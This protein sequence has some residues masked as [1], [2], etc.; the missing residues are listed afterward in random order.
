G[1]RRFEM[2]DAREL[3]GVGRAVVPLVRAGDAVVDEPVPHRLPR[4]AAVVG[5]L[6]QLPEPARALRRVQPIRVGRRSREMVD[7]PASKVGTT[8]VPPFALSVRLEDESALPRANQYPQSA[9]RSLLVSRAPPPAPRLIP[10]YGRMAGSRF[11]MPGEV[12]SPVATALEEAAGGVPARAASAPRA[13]TRE[14]RGVRWPSALLHRNRADVV[15]LAEV[16]AVV[17]EDR[18][19]HRRMEKEVRQREVHQVVVATEPLPA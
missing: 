8:D 3:P 15:H 14:L 5:T 18:V 7:L 16:D 17:A 10:L 6:H 4:L 19:R 2:P 9:H 13:R 12:F 1:Q 11:D